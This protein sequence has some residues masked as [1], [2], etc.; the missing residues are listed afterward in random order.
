MN[1][2]QITA[3][4][5]ELVLPQVEEALL[6]N[7]YKGFTLYKAAGRGAYADTY[8]RNHLSEHIVM[9]IYVDKRDVEYVAD[10]LLNA[11]HT[12]VE[13]EG[14]VSI[15]PVEKLYWINSKAEVSSDDLR[16]TGRSYEE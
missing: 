14:I 11:A 2:R 6:S 16:S 1:I 10:I 3:T 5:D 4:F 13:G 15:S 8:N 7:G 12:N 9:T